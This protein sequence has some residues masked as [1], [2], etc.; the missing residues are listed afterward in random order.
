MEGLHKAINGS[1]A[2]FASGT[3]VRKALRTKL[4]KNRCSLKELP[5]TQTF[6]KVALPM[7]KTCPYRKIINLK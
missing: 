3:L 6:T 7:A 2:F 1:Y 4:I 5:I